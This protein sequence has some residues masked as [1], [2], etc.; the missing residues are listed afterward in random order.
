MFDV[1][2]S[3]RGQ[4]GVALIITL[5]MLAVITFLATTFLV[6]SRREAESVNTNTDQTT[7]RFAADTGLERAKVE[8]LSAILATKNDQNLNLQTTI[9]NPTNVSYW[10][11]NGNPLAYNDLIINLTNLIYNPRPPVFVTNRV[12]GGWDFRFFLDLNRNGRFEPT[13]VIPET[14][15]LGQPIVDSGNVTNFVSVN[16]DPQWIGVLRFPER[17]H[18]GDNPFLSRWT[19]L[20]VPADKVLDVNY[21]HNQAVTR[22][23]ALGNPDGY[24]RNQ[25]V[26]PWEINLAAFL[27]DL[28]TNVWNNPLNN[29]YD[30]RRW[31]GNPNLGLAFE[32]AAAL[33]RYRYAFN[34]N[35]LSPADLV[36]ANNA[37]VWLNDGINMYSD[38][39]PRFMTGTA[40]PVET[41]GTGDQ[42][43]RSW[44]GS[45]NT[46]HYFT[47]QDLFD[48]AKVA[49]GI[50]LPTFSFV[51][52]LT[53]ASARLDTYDQYTFYRMIS[54]LGMD[55]EPERKI[56]VN[57]LNVDTNGNIIPGLETNMIS[58]GDSRIG[59]AGGITVNGKEVVPPYAPPGPLL[60]F[61]TAASAMFQR[62]DLHENGDPLGRLIT[63]TNIP[64]WPTNHYTPAVH[65]ILQLAA[66]IFEATTNTLYPSI[67]RPVFSAR[68]TNI[69]ITDYEQV[70]GPDTQ[71]TPAGFLT[72]PIDINDPA[73]NQR[74]LIRTVPTALNVYGVP[75]IIGARKGLPNFNELAMQSVCQITRKLQVTRPL[76]RKPQFEGYSAKQM[77]IVGVSNGLAVE[78]W[79][80]YKTN[81]P[82][83]VYLQAD[84]TLTMSLTN[85][86]GYVGPLFKYALG[87]AGVGS[88][89]IPENQWVGTG[90]IPG[91]PGN[92]RIPV[93][94]SFVVP[95][96]TNL[97]LLQDSYAVGNRVYPVATYNG[98]A[99]W[100]S[101]AIN[102][103]AQPQW[104]VTITNNIRC[105]IIDGGP[106][107]R[108]IDYVQ[109]SHLE[110]PRNLSDE[111][112]KFNNTHN[113]WVTNMNAQKQLWMDVQTVPEG[114]LHQILVSM[115]SEQADAKE[116][117]DYSPG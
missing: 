33:L 42:P 49:N 2:R 93:P 95:L 89:N 104:E 67:Y 7:A 36:F 46:N 39:F 16:G 4:R 8:L 43:T 9:S 34:Y 48:R 40:L 18:S 58:W 97:V 92:A 75:W 24:A 80:S 62:M 98:D 74:G 19:Y 29:P 114:I 112:L 72:V 59:S 103:L 56:N 1:R 64:I 52:R 37:N 105:M 32:D 73:P 68:G 90:I 88:T 71:V 115:G 78:F 12:A 101:L 106:T 35:T 117:R 76:I 51:D 83:Q 45:D 61:K 81:Y 23:V 13:G 63:V 53:N 79:N 30:Y 86:Q 77:F 20:V 27:A 25:G 110:A 111:A 55:S 28:N 54:Q 60:F 113:I 41:S 57:Y 85:D 47:T 3:A 10:Y 11:K 99:F 96:M 66:N 15:S 82:R 109:L 21:I 26:G 5:I 69:Y 65:R 70:N 17:P 116:W 84:G 22:N 108:V 38:G 107:G 50:S 87:G 91:G 102:N 94:Q 14:N 6:L 44:L 31:Q 100:N